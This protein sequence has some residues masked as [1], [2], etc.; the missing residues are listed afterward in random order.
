[1]NKYLY[2]GRVMKFD[3]CIQHRWGCTTY[4]VSEKEAR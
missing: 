2:D 4:A 3:I 1:M